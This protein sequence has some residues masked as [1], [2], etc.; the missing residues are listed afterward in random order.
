MTVP[1]VLSRRGGTFRPHYDSDETRQEAM[2][3]GMLAATHG[4][5]LGERLR[6]WWRLIR[7]APGVLRGTRLPE[8]ARERTRCQ[9]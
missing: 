5:S 7:L 2:L 8:Q 6:G 1:Q 4:P 9:Q 3:R